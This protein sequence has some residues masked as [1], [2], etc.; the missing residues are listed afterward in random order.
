MRLHRFSK[1]FPK[2]GISSFSRVHVFT[3]W[4]TRFKSWIPQ[5]VNIYRNESDEHKRYFLDLFVNIFESIGL[6]KRIYCIGRLAVK[7]QAD[8]LGLWCV[9]ATCGKV[10]SGRIWNID[11]QTI[12]CCRSMRGRN[13]STRVICGKTASRWSGD[14]IR[15]NHLRKTTSR[16]IGNM[17]GTGDEVANRWRGDMVG[18]ESLVAKLQSDEW[19]IWLD[20]SHLGQNCKPMKGRYVWIGVTCGQTANDQI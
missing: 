2:G 6:T 14:M 20:S 13:G 18:F 12:R 5:L 15:F 10:A 4:G 1:T 19:E 7:L 9:R 3:A 8:G 16:W 17:S 11:G